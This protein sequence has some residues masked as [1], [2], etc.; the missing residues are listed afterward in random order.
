MF[1]L[2]VRVS[3]DSVS[4]RTDKVILK[5]DRFEGLVE[6]IQSYLLLKTELPSKLD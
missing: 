1:T 5:K 4:V 6:V 3:I 2:R